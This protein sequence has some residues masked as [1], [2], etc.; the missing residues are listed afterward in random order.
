[1]LGHENPDPVTHREVGDTGA[2]RVHHSGAVV[3]GDHLGE[4]ELLARVRA[5]PVLPIGRVDTRQHD[6]HPYL[7][8]VGI[9]NL[10]VVQLKNRGISS[11][12]VGDRLHETHN[13]MRG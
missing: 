12:G 6:A 9:G 10:T 7:P 8:D 1:M 2:D 13:A 11:L 3:V 5:H 4:L